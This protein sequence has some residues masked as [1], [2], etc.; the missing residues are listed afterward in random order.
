LKVLGLKHPNTFFTEV[1][2]GGDNSRDE[3]S[4]APVKARESIDISVSE[5]TCFSHP[6]V[7]LDFIQDPTQTSFKWRSLSN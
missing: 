1:P 2:P 6:S 5:E 7:I 3:K 4:E